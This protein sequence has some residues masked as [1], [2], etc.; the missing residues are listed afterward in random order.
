MYYMRQVDLL[1]ILTCNCP[2]TPQDSG[3]RE[4]LP[5]SCAENLNARAHEH[6]AHESGRAMLDRC[7]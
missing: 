5:L 3:N 6:E 2:G 4:G 1:L 7:V